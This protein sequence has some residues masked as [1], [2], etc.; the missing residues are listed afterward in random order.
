M[1]VVD[2][3]SGLQQNRKRLASLHAVE[4]PA[5]V[6]ELQQQALGVL[7]AQPPDAHPETQRHDLERPD[8][9]REHQGHHH[10][11]PGA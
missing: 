6:K 10:H 7:D 11:K 3:R 5:Q 1:R 2:G 9:E 8:D 4:R